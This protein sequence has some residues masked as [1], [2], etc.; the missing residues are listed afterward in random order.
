MKAIHGG[1]AKNDRIDSLKI[2]TLL[3]GGMGDVPTL[4]ENLSS[5]GSLAG[6]RM[7]RPKPTVSGRRQGAAD[8]KEIRE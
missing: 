4:V 5:S 7:G 3:R 8:E 6:L 1:K 2:A